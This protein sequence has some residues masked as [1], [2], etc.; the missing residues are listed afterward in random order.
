MDE[1]PVSSPCAVLPPNAL[2]GPGALLAHR[3]GPS[4]TGRESQWRGNGHSPGFPRGIAGGLGL[5]IFGAA[6]A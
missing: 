2:A 4:S 3:D 1:E 5:A 6:R